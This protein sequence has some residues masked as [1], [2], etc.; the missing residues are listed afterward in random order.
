M[1]LANE[2]KEQFLFEL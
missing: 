2:D 1:I